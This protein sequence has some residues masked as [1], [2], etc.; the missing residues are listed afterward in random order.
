[1][2]GNANLYFTVVLKSS[3]KDTEVGALLLGNETKG[4]F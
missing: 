1:M 4:N 3:R 2:L